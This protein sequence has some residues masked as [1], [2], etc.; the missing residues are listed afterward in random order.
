MPIT[1]DSIQFNCLSRRV[2]KVGGKCY[3]RRAYGTPMDFYCFCCSALREQD[4]KY[5]H[6]RQ[7]LFWHLWHKGHPLKCEQQHQQQP[8][9][10]C[11][12]NNNLYIEIHPRIANGNESKLIH[13]Q[14]LSN[15]LSE[16]AGEQQDGRQ[17]GRQKR[18]HNK[19][20]NN[21][22]AQTHTHTH[23]RP[24]Q[25]EALAVPHNA[26]G[27]C[28]SRIVWQSQDSPQ[29]FCVA[30]AV[31]SI[32]G[33]RQQQ[34]QQQQLRQQQK[35]LHWRHLSFWLRATGSPFAPVLNSIKSICPGRS[36]SASSLPA[37]A[38]RE[39]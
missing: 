16:A 3:Q 30:H 26:I 13:P 11:A 35:Q 39:I 24:S 33:V 7:C 36:A 25:L 34:Q 20:D 4:V 9:S 21:N 17:A 2:R 19:K 29:D 37:Y 18:S 10:T 14:N 38:P 8:Q 23:A 1:A 5:P 31:G 15:A 12:K 6:R 27:S 28:C 22:R 32:P